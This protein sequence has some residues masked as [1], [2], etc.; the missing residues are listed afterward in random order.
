MNDGEGR[1]ALVTG[2]PGG[3]GQAIC[4]GLASAGDVVAVHHHGQSAAAAGLALELGRGSRAF[5]RDLM[6]WSAASAL[7]SEVEDVFGRIDILVNNAGLMYEAPVESTDEELWG[8]TMAL[9]LTAVMAMVKA[10]SQGMLT[11]GSGRIIN[12][13]SQLA[14]IGGSNLSAYAAAKAGVVG[15]TKA[16]ARELGPTI[17]VNAVAPGPTETSMIA[18][19]AD[20]D[21]RASRTRNLVSG[22]VAQPDE[23]AN[24]VLF[25]ASD[26]ARLFHG[27]VLH[28]NG[29][30]YLG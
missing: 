26:S 15:L 10:V 27:Q 4:R 5:D 30:G 25:L 3:L 21:W 20:A 22:R 11:R 1:I 7:V 8:R 19:F 14:F 16:L 9:D 13:S 6:T 23:V 12:M 29:G 18:P 2:A 24:A 17:R 28:A